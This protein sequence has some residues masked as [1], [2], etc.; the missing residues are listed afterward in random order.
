MPDKWK[1]RPTRKSR[2]VD[3]RRKKLPPTIGVNRMPLTAYIP[4]IDVHGKLLQFLVPEDGEIGPLSL[5]LGVA[6]YKSAQVKVE[7]ISEEENYERSVTV[8]GGT[9]RLIEIEEV[10]GVLK[11]D[12][13][14][15]TM[16]V[17]EDGAEPAVIKDVWLTALFTPS[18]VVKRRVEE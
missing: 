3:Q 14:I 15:L 1:G 9:N 12:R 17:L 10:L 13:V 4:S 6:T 18:Q 5:F 11:G 2:V 16:S 8:G 7:V